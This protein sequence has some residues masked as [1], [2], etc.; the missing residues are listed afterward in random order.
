MT[1][2]LPML[3]CKHP[4]PP[5]PQTLTAGRR[6]VHRRPCL[7]KE[8]GETG[9][10]LQVLPGLP[11]SAAGPT[12]RTELRGLGL[13]FPSPQ[14]SGPTELPGSWHCRRLCNRGKLPSFSE[15]LFPPLK[16][17]RLAQVLFV[18]PCRSQVDVRLL[19]Q[20]LATPMHKRPEVGATQGPGFSFP[21]V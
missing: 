8:E 14:R 17:Q 7:G 11:V 10:R 4:L 18:V 1:L 3:C 2:P 13:T 9:Q 5:A 15:P 20:L 6:C 21:D 12:A 19:G 16:L